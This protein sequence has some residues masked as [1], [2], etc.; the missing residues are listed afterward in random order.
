MSLNETI[1]KGKEEQRVCT[2]KLK[3]MEANLKD[4][5]G[6]RERQLKEAKDTMQKLK[7]KSEKSKKEW[8]KHEQVHL[9]RFFTDSINRF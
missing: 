3:E 7:S 2:E 8:K 6:Y 9:N 5:K 4:A 1:E